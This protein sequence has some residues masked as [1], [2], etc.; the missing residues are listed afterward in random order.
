MLEANVEQFQII[1]GVHYRATIASTRAIGSCPTLGIT[2]ELSAPLVAQVLSGVATNSGMSTV[3]SGDCRT[4]TLTIYKVS[5]NSI[6]AQSSIS[7]NNI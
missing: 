4:W 1:D 7:V 5:D 3:A 2:T 6:F